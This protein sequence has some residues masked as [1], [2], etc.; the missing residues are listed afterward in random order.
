M[1]A[2]AG[3]KT[4]T[5]EPRVGTPSRRRWGS[6]KIL[7]LVLA[8]LSI[9]VGLP[10]AG[11]VWLLLKADATLRNAIAEADRLD[12][13][14]RLEAIL[15]AREK[16]V[17]PDDEDAAACVLRVLNLI[18]ADWQSTDPKIREAQGPYRGYD[19]DEK[20]GKLRPDVKLSDELAAGLKAEVE[21]LAPALA[22]ARPLAGMS[23]GR[24]P[25]EY[26]EVFFDTKLPHTQDSRKV[27]RLLRLSATHRA[28]GGDYDGALDDCRAIIGVSHAIGDEP[29]TISQLVRIA[30]VS[31]ALGTLVRVLAQGEASDAALARVQDRL[32]REAKVPFS[33]IGLRGERA[34]FFDMLGK[35]AGGSISVT[36]LSHF[37]ARRSG[38]VHLKPHGVAF[39]RYNQGLCLSLMTRAIEIEKLPLSEQEVRW[40]EW[41]ALARPPKNQWYLMTGSLTYILIPGFHAFHTAHKRIVGLLN[42]AQ[43][44]VAMERYR[45]TNGRW[46]KSL[47]EIPKSI[48]PETPID[49]YSSKPV[50][51]AQKSDGW[52]VY[53]VGTDGQDNGGKLDPNFNP[54][55][56]GSD[57]GYHLWDVSHRRRPPEP[58]DKKGTE[59]KP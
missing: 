14:W 56:K 53:C 58:E 11:Y 17:I 26:A 6:L 8:I 48:L 49:P 34:S 36:E 15:E 20:V 52:A 4:E 41:E 45:L 54:R 23:R 43:V 46:P 44:M 5:P 1:S 57:W 18:P 47:G 2:S 33:T 30:E 21:E 39:Y 27:V 35:L 7:G 25:I 31:F 16:D 42:V 50:R 19:L 38:P 12:P 51:I 37:P 32:A 3:R 59:P 29:T 40:A 13:G 55:F 24:L 10:A 9:V 28:Q 22:E